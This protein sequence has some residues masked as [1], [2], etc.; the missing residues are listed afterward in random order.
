MTDASPAQTPQIQPQAQAKAQ[1]VNM[2]QAPSPPPAQAQEQIHAPPETQAQSTPENAPHKPL[3]AHTRL[4]TAVEDANV[5]LDFA[6]RHA[7]DIEHDIVAPLIASHDKTAQGDTLSADEQAQFWAALSAIVDRVKPVTVESIHFTKQRLDAPQG[8]NWF[9]RLFAK[10]CPA[11]QILRRYLSVAVLTLFALL[12]LQMEWAIGMAIFNDAYKVH[13][14][15]LNTTSQLA[16]A[17]QMSESLKGSD[18]SAA[19]NAL[20]KLD[21]LERRYAQDGSWS[22]VSYV[23]LWWWN[24]QVAALLPPYDLRLGEEGPPTQAGIVKLNDEGQRR[25]E[26]TRAQL[27]LE[28]ISDYVLVALFALLGS[29]TQALRSLSAEIDAVSLTANRVYFIRT[30]IILGVIS[31]VCMAWLIITTSRNAGVG[32]PAIHETP[33][34][35]ISFLGAFAPWALAFISGYSVE[36]FFAAL[37]RAISFITQRIDAISLSPAETPMKSPEK[38]PAQGAQQN[39]AQSQKAPPTPASTSAPTPTPPP[40]SQANPATPQAN[41]ATTQATSQATVPATAPSTPPTPQS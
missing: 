29:M 34:S 10:S 12:A 21:T 24:R 19:A 40:T 9:S 30:R 31:G 8:R 39:A 38:G 41:P 36:I 25:I 33:L 6:A 15:F 2:A 35:S 16:Q 32:D 26:F 17:K 14:N 7:I 23:R 20:V 5:L 1:N 27:T 37:E 11:D 28:V 4:I 13:G 3:V 22:D 18:T